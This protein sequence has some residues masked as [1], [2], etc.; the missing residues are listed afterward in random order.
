MK[1]IILGTGSATPSLLRNPSAQVLITDH[2]S[3]LIDCGEGTQMQLLKH[4]IKLNKI[5]HIFI[6]H[7]HGDH[8]FGLIGLISSLNLANR[9]E[10]LTIFGPKGLDQII[11]LQLKY[12]HSVVHFKLSFIEI[13]PESSYILLDNEH[14]T[15]STIPLDH[16]VSCTGFIFAEKE[17]KRNLIKDKIPKEIKFEEIAQL[18][19]GENILNSNGSVKYNFLDFTFSQ[20]SAKKYAYCSDTAYSEKI[21]TQ[22]NGVDLLYHEATFRHDLLERAKITHHST[23]KQAGQIAKQA[24][25]KQLIIGHF[26]SRYID[27]Q[28]NLE[29]AKIEFENTLLAIEGE[30]FLI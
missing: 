23:A 19:N 29:E 30:T 11:S 4:K 10:P 6:S 21:I 26:S 14:I 27:L 2:E 18:K 12:G 20:N 13:E 24:E 3:Y 5:K 22:I 17:Q 16:R 8:Y 15:I 9:T 28:E 25:V 7:L 1:L